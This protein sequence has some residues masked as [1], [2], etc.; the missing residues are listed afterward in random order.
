MN[1][2]NLV[3]KDII[4][5]EKDLRPGAKVLFGEKLRDTKDNRGAIKQRCIFNSTSPSAIVSNRANEIKRDH[6]NQQGLN[7]YQE[8]A[9]YVGADLG[10]SS[11]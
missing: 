7:A 5:Q 4:T 6:L 11:Q 10:T 8:Q 1:A 2:S 9:N 3:S